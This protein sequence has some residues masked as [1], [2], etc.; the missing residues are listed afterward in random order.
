MLF[1][2]CCTSCITPASLAGP[3][4]DRAG[5]AQGTMV[6]AAT[7]SLS[8]PQQNRRE[9]TP[10]SAESH[11]TLEGSAVPRAG[12]VAARY[13]VAHPGAAERPGRVIAMLIG[14][15]PGAIPKKRAVLNIYGCALFVAT[16]NS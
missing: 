5:R 4:C 1:S 12:G 9:T 10:T 14:S 11:A 6:P 13:W 2:F 8:Q 16:K 15:L 3:P 7:P